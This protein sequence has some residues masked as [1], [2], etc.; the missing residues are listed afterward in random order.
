MITYKRIKR[1]S[2]RHFRT[3]TAYILNIGRYIKSKLSCCF[4]NYNENQLHE[5]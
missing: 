4:H 1:Q 3:K 2:R 5:I